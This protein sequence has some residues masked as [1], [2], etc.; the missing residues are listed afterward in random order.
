M[1]PIN[2]Y[3]I[4]IFEI[5]TALKNSNKQEF[6]N[7]DLCKIFEYY[8]CIK[9]SEEYNKPFYEYDDIDP[10]FKELNKMS[11]YDTGID[12]SDLLNAIVQCKLRKDSL[13]QGERMWN[14]LW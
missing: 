2:R 4:N 14:I 7:K 8:S 11:R 13:T 12:C 1:E 9:L 10:S 5:Y 3:K 6:N